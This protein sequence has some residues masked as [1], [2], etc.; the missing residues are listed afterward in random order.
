MGSLADLTLQ[1]ERPA[2]PVPLD[3]QPEGGHSS[4]SGGNRQP[5]HGAG[6]TNPMKIDMHA[7]ILP[8]HWPDLA[9]KYGYPGWPSITHD[10][11]C[12]CY[13]SYGGTELEGK[14]KMLLDGKFFRQVESTSWSAEDRIKDCNTTGVTVQ[15][16]ST[17]PVMFAYWAKPDDTLDLARYLND[18]IAQTVAEN[19]KRYIG[20]PV[21]CPSY[22]LCCA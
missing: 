19:P 21:T 20:T 22:L 13:T 1:D 15:V 8:K 12:A 9:K 11:P 17:V 5:H 2:A 3:Q 16:L 4:S 14:A 6:P 7:H 18:H 10:E